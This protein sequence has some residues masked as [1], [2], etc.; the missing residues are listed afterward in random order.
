VVEAFAR[1]EN[2]GKGVISLNGQMVELLHLQQAER[3]IAIADAIRRM[4]S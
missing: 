1:P 4:E 3:V 2:R